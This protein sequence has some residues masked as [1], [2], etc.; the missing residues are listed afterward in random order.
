MTRRCGANCAVHM[1]G[2]LNHFKNAKATECRLG[3]QSVVILIENLPPLIY[4]RGGHFI[5][6]RNKCYFNQASI[7]DV[8]ETRAFVFD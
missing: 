6:F 4:S 2:V 3:D 5:Q 7:N 1:K 8:V